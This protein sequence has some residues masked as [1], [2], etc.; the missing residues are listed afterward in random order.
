M[1]TVVVV[2]DAAFMRLMLKDILV[3]AGHRVV[4][5]GETGEEAVDL[6]QAYRPDVMTLDMVM[7]RKMGLAAAEEILTK[8]PRARLIM[9]S[10]VGQEEVAKQALKIGVRAYLL[11]PFRPDQVK[12]CVTDVLAL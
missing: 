4:A 10:S 11:K 6:Y 8:D 1:A 9:V 7:P 12:S 2:D 3:E 5:E